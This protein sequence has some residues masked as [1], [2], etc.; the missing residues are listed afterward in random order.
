MRAIVRHPECAGFARYL[1]IT[2]VIPT[3]A[4]EVVQPI[5]PSPLMGS[6]HNLVAGCCGLQAGDDRGPGARIGRFLRQFRRPGPA[7]DAFRPSRDE[8]T[9]F[10]TS[11]TRSQLMLSCSLNSE[12]LRDER[13]SAD[14]NVRKC[15]LTRLSMHVETPSSRR[16]RCH[17]DIQTQ[18]HEL[19]KEPLTGEG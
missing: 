14:Q 2:I 4:E 15:P 3:I 13:P 5:I 11:P 8:W 16:C 7:G 1:C 6:L 17:A 9:P 10:K 19:C 18:S 12:L